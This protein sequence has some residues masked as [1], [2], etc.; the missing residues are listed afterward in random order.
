M[1]WLQDPSQNNVG[2][3]SNIRLESN[4]HFMNKKKEY[5]T[6]KIDDL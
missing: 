3:L 4:I 6:A 2:N 5:V 1:Q